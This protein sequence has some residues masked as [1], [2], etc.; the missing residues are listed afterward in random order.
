MFK[1]FD[2][3]HNATVVSAEVQDIVSLNSISTTSRVITSTVQLE[4]P[5]N[6]ISNY[7]LL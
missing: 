4:I 2:T 3:Q 1:S 6:S 5:N 7:Q